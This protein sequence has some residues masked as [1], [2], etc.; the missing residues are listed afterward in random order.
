MHIITYI[1]V[2]NDAY[3]AASYASERS[4]ARGN[5]HRWLLQQWFQRRAIIAE[6]TI[7][8]I[9]KPS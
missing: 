3:D 9:M 2:C 4:P 6:A 8:A 5:R 1:I 7:E